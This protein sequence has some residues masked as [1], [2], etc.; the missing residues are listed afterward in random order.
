MGRLPQLNL[1]RRRWLTGLV[2]AILAATAFFVALVTVELPARLKTPDSVVVTWRDGSPAHV[3]LSPDERWRMQVG[4][5]DVAPAYVDALITFE[6]KRFWSHPGVDPLAIVRAAASNLVSGRRVSGASTI[7]MQVVRLLEPRSRTF[8]SKLIESFRAVQLELFFSKREILEQYLRLAPFGKNVEGVEAASWAYFGHS[9]RVL[10]AEEI[11]VLLAVPQGPAGRYPRPEN[12]A[13][14]RA[15]RDRISRRL[16]DEGLLP[17][18]QQGGQVSAQQLYDMIV[19][20]DPPTSIRSFPREIPHLAYWARQKHP[21][22]TVIPTT[23]EAG[24]QRIVDEL[25]RRRRD[26]ALRAGANNISVVVA[27]H[28]SMEVRALVGNFSFDQAP[29]SQIPSFDVPR[30]PGSLLKPFVLAAAIDLGLALPR[31]L[32]PDIP[33][34]AG[35]YAPEN[36]DGSFSGLARL[37]DALVRSLNIPF[38]ALLNEVGVENFIAQIRAMGAEHIVE[39]PGHYGLTV[40]VGGL[41]MTPLEVTAAYATLARGGAT[42]RLQVFR[43]SPT[44][45][46]QVYSQGAT[47]LVRQVLQARDRP[48]FSAR[49]LVN[50]HGRRV[51]W[52]TGTSFGNRDAWAVGAGETT[53]VSVWMGNHDRTGSSA[54]VGSERSGPLLFDVL[55]AVEHEGAALARPSELTEIE[56]CAYSGHIPGPACETRAQTWALRQKVPTQTCP[57]HVHADVEVSTGLVLSAECRPGRDYVTRSFLQWPSAVRRYLSP[58][59]RSGVERPDY[60]SGC[61]PRQN[62]APPVIVAPPPE[63]TILLR[64]DIPN[65]QQQQP[66]EADATDSTMKINWYVDGVHVG[67]GPAGERQWWTPTP[68]RHEVVVMDELG[69][70]TRRYVE[71]R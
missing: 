7:T 40:A 63:R 68:G 20:A 53:T 65:D 8:S 5:D 51:F 49:R 22:A 6:D 55:D 2:V 30:S 9:A 26:E 71:V 58:R 27:D 59:S 44:T 69:R 4:Q 52:K 64:P 66:L 54:L 24:T 39:T 46:L 48:D 47:W 14:L 32:V 35:T 67:S 21:G 25:V 50:P 19:A 10:T 29:G 13:R 1:K 57:F 23:L 37:D 18:G 16:L 41:E 28:Q 33:F 61:R 15:A 62:V 12:Q 38:V 42:G 31:Y 36:F 60:A 3:F 17:R 43:E 45:D 70:S 56:V 11:A 34:R